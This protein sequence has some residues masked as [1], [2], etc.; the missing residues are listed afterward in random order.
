M[1][2][3]ES[4][5]RAM[6]ER[7]LK[8]KSVK[9]LVDSD[10]DCVAAFTREATRPCE[11][12]VWLIA[13]GA[14]KDVFRVFVRSDQRFPE[15]KWGEVLAACNEWNRERRWPKTYLEISKEDGRGM[16]VCEEQWDLERGIHQELLE[17]FAMIVITASHQ[18]WE[19]AHQER[20]L[21]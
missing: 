13:A 17:D 18:F 5:S 21:Y 7:A 4:F 1:P 19:W 9:Y 20:K 8:N 12:E 15:V 10:G 14:K 6:I 11:L 2:K 3:V 16:I